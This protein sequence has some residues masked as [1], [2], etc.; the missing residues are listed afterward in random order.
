MPGADRW[1]LVGSVIVVLAALALIQFA[2][3]FARSPGR[4]ITFTRLTGIP[5]L[6]LVGFLSALEAQWVVVGVVGTCASQLIADM[7]DGAAR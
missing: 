1:L 5:F 2:S 3:T 4:H 6:V 7:T